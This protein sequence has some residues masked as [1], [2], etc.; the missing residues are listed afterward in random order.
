MAQEE[1]NEEGTVAGQ[2]TQEAMPMNRAMRRA[3]GIDNR[4]EEL[5]LSYVQSKIDEALS[6]GVPFD[7]SMLS[8]DEFSKILE[9]KCQ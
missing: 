1:G 2:S 9:N 4:E 5:A 8:T 7:E 6:Q 3:A